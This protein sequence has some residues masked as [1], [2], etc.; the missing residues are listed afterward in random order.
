MRDKQFD[1]SVL[2]SS[3]MFGVLAL[4]LLVVAVEL[5]I[6]EAN[7][8]FFLGLNILEWTNPL[9]EV[10]QVGEVSLES[11]DLILGVFVWLVESVVEPLFG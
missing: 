11:A 10:R 9:E 2:M 3:K 5:S 7:S 1:F 4:L 8:W 6:G